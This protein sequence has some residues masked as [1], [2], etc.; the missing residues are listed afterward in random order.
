MPHFTQ[1]VSRGEKINLI[2]TGNVLS[3]KEEISSIFNKSFEYTVPNLNIPTAEHS[4]SNLQ[5]TGPILTIVDWYDK[6]PSIERMNNSSCNSMS[7]KP[8]QAKLIK[9][10]IIGISK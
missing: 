10:L 9:S 8:F 2:E 7:E 6:H 5:G 3:N 1:K 4:S